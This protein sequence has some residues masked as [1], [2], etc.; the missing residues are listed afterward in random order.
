MENSTE[1]RQ[2]YVLGFLFSSDL[3]GVALIQKNRPEWCAGKLNGIGGKIEPGEDPLNA[4]RREFLEEAGA[5]VANWNPVMTLFLPAGVMHVF[6]A[7]GDYI[8]SSLTDEPV[9]WRSTDTPPIYTPMMDNLPPLIQLA[10]DAV[11]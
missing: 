3:S 7:R 1:T 5:D 10:V 8:V 4:M 6:A 2:Q 9:S 11:K